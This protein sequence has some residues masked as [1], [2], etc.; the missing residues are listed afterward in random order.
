MPGGAGIEMVTCTSA[1][2][3]QEGDLGE[4]SYWVLDHRCQLSC[5][6]LKHANYKINKNF[7]E[8]SQVKKLALLLTLLALVCWLPGQAMAD[9]IC[10]TFDS[11]FP[12]LVPDDTN[13]LPTTDNY[14]NLHIDFDGT[15]ATITVTPVSNATFDFDFAPPTDTN[16]SPKVLALSIKGGFN[17]PTGLTAGWAVAATNAFAG[18]ALGNFDLVL[19][20]TN[21]DAESVTFSI[22]K[23]SGSWADASSVLKFNTSGFDAGAYLIKDGTSKKGYVGEGSPV[24]L[25]GAMLLLGAGLARLTAYARR[26]RD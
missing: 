3:L 16:L 15:T 9:S 20:N 21:A 26:R 13:P 12:Y 14:C 24:P 1:G 23:A 11:P 19:T 6:R 10:T 17:S 18:G 7:K 2:R 4:I 8:K 22:T 25:P 5:R